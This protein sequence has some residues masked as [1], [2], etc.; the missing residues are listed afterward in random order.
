MA[1]SGTARPNMSEL[2]HCYVVKVRI[3]QGKLTYSYGVLNTL[4]VIQY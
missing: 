1:S 3:F 4:N 2:T